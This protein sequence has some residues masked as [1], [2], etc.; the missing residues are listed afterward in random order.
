MC[1]PKPEIIMTHD[2]DPR[3]DATG[4][5]KMLGYSGPSAIFMRRAR[6]QSLPPAVQIPG[7]RKM[8]WRLSSVL[9]WM[10]EHEMPLT[11]NPREHSVDGQ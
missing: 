9:A 10:R 3:I 4:L 1:E 11:P 7:C 8:F 5:A 2:N 6:G